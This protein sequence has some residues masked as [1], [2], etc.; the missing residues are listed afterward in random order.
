MEAPQEYPETPYSLGANNCGIG[1]VNGDGYDDFLVNREIR[2]FWSGIDTAAVN[3]VFLF[4]G[5]PILKTEPDLIFEEHFNGVDFGGF[6]QVMN[7]LGDVNGDGYD[8]FA[9]CAH[10]AVTDTMPWGDIAHGGKVYVHF[11]GSILDTIPDLIF[12]GN[13]RPWPPFWTGGTFASAVCGADVNGDGY[14]DILIGSADYA[15]TI[16]WYDQ[17]RGRVYIYFGGPSVDTIADIIITGGNY[18]APFP[19]RYEQLG[20]AIDNLGD[21]NNDG[22]EDIVVGAPN[23]MEREAAAGKVY[24]FYGGIRMD[25]IPDWWYYGEDFLQCLGEA[26]SNAGDFN[27]DGYHDIMIGD[28]RYVHVN[29]DRIKGRALIFYG[30]PLLDTVPDWQVLG[31]YGIGSSVDC[32]GDVN[33]DV[34]T[35]S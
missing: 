16:Q 7:G 10:Y 5:G 2:G 21:V 4:L 15:P 1:D 32:V 13:K 28:Y 34:M 23:N 11:G 3:R 24:L 29:G 30:G 20:A 17:V 25:T 35:M 18:Y 9:I 12:K 31:Q 19:A 6:G 22:Y 33:G 8:D 14:H 27:G 26:V